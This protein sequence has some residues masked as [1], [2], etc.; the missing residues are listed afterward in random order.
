MDALE[1]LMVL[2][3]G[4]LSPTFTLQEPGEFGRILQSALVIDAKALSD[5]LRAET[6][7]F[8]GD[9]RTKIEAMIVKGTMKECNTTVR[10][11]SSEVQ[12]SDGLTKIGAR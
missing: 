11:I 12:Y 10:W 4:C 9:K 2:W 3:Q 5:C 7:Q 8:Q 6:P 1:Y